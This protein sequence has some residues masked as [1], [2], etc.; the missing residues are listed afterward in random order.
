MD[1]A[2]HAAWWP[3]FNGWLAGTGVW[4]AR[5]WWDAV[6]KVLIEA[7]GNCPGTGAGW[8]GVVIG[9]LGPVAERIVWEVVYDY[10]VSSGGHVLT[11]WVAASKAS[12]VLAEV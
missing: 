9:A 1:G 10:C 12:E 8:K 6:A 2:C 11:D 5:G 3:V 4:E 7:V